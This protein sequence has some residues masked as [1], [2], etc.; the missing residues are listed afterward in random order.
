MTCPAQRCAIRRLTV[1]AVLIGFAISPVTHAQTITVLHS[2]TNNADGSNPTAGMIM[3]RAGNLY[4]TTSG[5]EMAVTSAAFELKAAGSGWL[6]KPLYD[7]TYDNRYVYGYA[8]YTKPVFGPDGALYVAAQVGGNDACPA[9]C[10]TVV[11]LQPQARACGSVLC[12]WNVT[13]LYAFSGPADGIFPDQIIFGPDGSIYGTTLWGGS[14]GGC[15]GNGCGTVY[16]LT[17]TGGQYWTKTTLY[18][19]HDTDGNYPI[20][21]V[22]FDAAGNLY[23][24]AIGGGN[25]DMGLVYEL[26]PVANGFWTQTILHAFQRS[27]GDAPVGPL[28]KDAS[29]NLYGVTKGGG[30]NM[31]GTVFEVSPP[32]TFQTLYNLSINFFGGGANGGLLLDS[33]GNIYGTTLAGG[34]NGDGIVFKLALVN[35]A[36]TFTDLHDFDIFD[37]QYPNGGLVFD[38]S[39]SIY[40]TAGYGGSIGR[41]TAWKL[42]P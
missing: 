28:T 35:G 4:G 25:N 1:I 38:T 23:G 8:L 7:F 5:V 33:A 13:V 18:E 20:G 14:G 17:N 9:G 27:D 39:G 12:P 19:F 26:T 3:D 32:G 15:G 37:G 36:W 34:I 41:G 40:G 42:T 6:L 11:K 2:F 29:G 16:K 22:T 10:G 31:G 30:A 24:T 21:G